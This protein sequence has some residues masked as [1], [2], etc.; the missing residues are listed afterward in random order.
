LTRGRE[1][2]C[3]FSDRNALHRP[4]VA[5]TAVA[6]A[7][8][9]GRASMPVPICW[10]RLV[11]LRRRRMLNTLVLGETVGARA[12]NQAGRCA[13]SVRHRECVT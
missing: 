3:D 13:V 4:H 9:I 5:R 11:A 7:P 10:C 8:R 1:R 2:V 6:A 12:R